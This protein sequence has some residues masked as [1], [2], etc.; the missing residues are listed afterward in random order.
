MEY[1]NLPGRK[2]VLRCLLHL[3]PS[4]GPY[5]LR[6]LPALLSYYYPLFLQELHVIPHFSRLQSI[7]QK[8]LQRKRH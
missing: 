2:I 6:L 8:Q 3:V 7:W 5:L 4:Y 1:I